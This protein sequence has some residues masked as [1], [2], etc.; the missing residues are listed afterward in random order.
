MRAATIG[1]GCPLFADAIINCIANAC[2]PT[3]QEL[4]SVA[5]RIW[6]DGAAQR[7]VFD[8]DTLQPE[9]AER[10]M[11]VRAAQLALCGSIMVPP[12]DP[13]PR[14]NAIRSSTCN[15]D[16]ARMR[17]GVPEHVDLSDR[18]GPPSVR[19]IQSIRT[20]LVA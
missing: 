19:A 2:D 1:P 20:R 16:G 15:S 7:S 10:L 11:A 14:D 12:G 3:V 6:T 18:T 17:R 5:E 8:W 4:F 13:F 9:S